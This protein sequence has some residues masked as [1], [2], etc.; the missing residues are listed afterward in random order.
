MPDGYGIRNEEVTLSCQFGP[1]VSSDTTNIVTKWYLN[2][3]EVATTQANE[4]YNI[5]SFQSSNSGN[6]SC[7]ILVM[8]G[9]TILGGVRSTEMTVR[10]AGSYI[11]TVYCNSNTNVQL[12]SICDLLN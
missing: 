11:Y 10:L 9:N 12:I 3:D 7:A 2:G 5:R 4:N 8:N 1:T 6:Y